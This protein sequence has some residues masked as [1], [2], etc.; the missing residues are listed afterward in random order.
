ME[1]LSIAASNTV[2]IEL[3]QNLT[4]ISH[5]GNGK[6]MLNYEKCSKFNERKV[7]MGLY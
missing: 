4:G 6:V 5:N 3:R 7:H 2:P 1:T